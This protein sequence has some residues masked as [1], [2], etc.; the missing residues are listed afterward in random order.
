[1][2]TAE[3]DTD[4]TPTV[5]TT[6]VEA[7]TMATTIDATMTDAMIIDVVED[8]FPAGAVVTGG[9][10]SQPTG[11]QPRRKVLTLNMQ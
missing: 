11:S 1:M 9:R 3:D 7:D 8:A 2:T 5:V 4:T 10:D 6:T